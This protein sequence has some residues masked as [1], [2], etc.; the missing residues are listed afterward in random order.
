MSHVFI[1]LPDELAGKKATFRFLKDAL[2]I[3]KLVTGKMSQGGSDFCIITSKY[4]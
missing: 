1:N 2:V 3:G 4:P